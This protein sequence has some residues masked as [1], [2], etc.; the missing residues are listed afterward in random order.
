M[1][2]EEASIIVSPDWMKLFKIMCDASGVAL[3]VFLGQKKEKLF[4]PIYYASKALN[5]AQK[6]YTVTEQELLVIVYAFEKFR[7]YLLGTKVA[8]HTDHFALR[9]P[10]A[11]RVGG[12]RWTNRW[13]IAA[14][15]DRNMEIKLPPTR[16]M[17]RGQRARQYPSQGSDASFEEEGEN[18]SSSS[19]S[20]SP[21]KEGVEISNPIQEEVP[22]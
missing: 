7:A 21:I 11:E 13:N 2:L 12:D 18:S 19:S 4:H 6:N 17:G 8:M 14:L 3:G 1:K 10:E 22:E 20:S 9:K 16:G 15:T 5:G